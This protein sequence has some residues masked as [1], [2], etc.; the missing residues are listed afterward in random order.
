LEGSPEQ[1]ASKSNNSS[2]IKEDGRASHIP[3]IQNLRPF[4][5]QRSKLPAPVIFDCSLEGAEGISAKRA[6][7]R[8]PGRKDNGLRA[9]QAAGA[10]GLIQSISKQ[11]FGSYLLSP[12][13][14]IGLI[15]DTSR[16]FTETPVADEW[17]I[18]MG[19]VSADVTRRQNDF[20]NSS[21]SW[22][23]NDGTISCRQNIFYK[24]P[25]LLHSHQ[26]G[27]IECNCAWPDLIA[28]TEWGAYTIENNIWENPLFCDEP[29]GDFGLEEVS[30]CGI[31]LAPP[32][33][34]LIGVSSEIC[35]GGS[36]TPN[37]QTTWGA[38]KLTY[39]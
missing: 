7:N 25:T 30:P 37:K 31:F 21:L 14:V 23:T 19:W 15:K 11:R 13:D 38:I 32:E 6:G 29:H 28:T 12:D 8:V 36:G 4:A 9:G 5:P 27:T 39:R 1:A 10:I 33:C 18:S 34:G 22:E 24:N 3:L 2:A 17:L 26:G 16:S 35:P 20:I